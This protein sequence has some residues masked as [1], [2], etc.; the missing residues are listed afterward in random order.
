MADRSDV[1]LAACKKGKGD[2]EVFMIATPYE[3]TLVS[4]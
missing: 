3:S 2:S 4:A 1:D